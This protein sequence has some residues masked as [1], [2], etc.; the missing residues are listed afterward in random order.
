MWRQAMTE[1]VFETLKGNAQSLKSTHLR[2]LLKDEARQDA[3]GMPTD[4][5]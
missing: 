1:K 4:M 5:K 2:E 3:H